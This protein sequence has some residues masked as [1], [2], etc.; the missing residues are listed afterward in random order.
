M[1]P[2]NFSK[3]QGKDPFIAEIAVRSQTPEEARRWT[4][5]VCT[6]TKIL[7][8]LKMFMLASVSFIY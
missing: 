4:I 3:I 2:G 5:F 1:H 6:S 8:S 7:K